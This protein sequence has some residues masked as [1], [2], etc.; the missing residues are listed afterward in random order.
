[1]NADLGTVT[2]KVFGRWGWKIVPIVVLWWA[3]FWPVGIIWLTLSLVTRYRAA[4]HSEPARA[5]RRASRLVSIYPPGW[6]ARYGDEIA[7]TVR[8]T[9]LDGHGGL[10][11]EANI[12]RE[13]SAA[14]WQTDRRGWIAMICWWL[15]WIPLVSQ[16]L[17]P[18]AIKLGGGTYRSWFLALFFPPGFLQWSVIVVMFMIGVIMLATA[19]RGTPALRRVRTF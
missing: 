18:L 13:S 5:A 19:V 4:D 3:V 9:V 2:S 8:Q 14:W 11:L 1:V 15:C 10:R 16:S 12:V 17:V 7:E 6:Q